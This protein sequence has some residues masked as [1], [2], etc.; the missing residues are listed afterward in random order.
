MAHDH[1]KAF[2]HH[3]RQLIGGDPAAALSDRQLLERFLADRDEAA[4][5]VLVRR[6]GPLVFGVCRRVLHNAH[7]A[8]DAFQATFLVLVRKAP[9]LVCDDR[10]GGF[11]YRVA[12]RLAVRAR[13]NEAR[14][15]QREVC[16]ALN[17]A[18]RLRRAGGEDDRVAALEEELQRLPEKHR[19]PLVLCY[20]EGKTNEQAA[21]ILC[22]PVGSMSARLN[23]ARQRLRESLEQR[24]VTV[25][26]AGIAALLSAAGTQAGVPLP[27]VCNTVRAAVWFAG[28]Q[29]GG[30]GFVSAGAVALARGAC[31]T[32]FL[33]RVNVIAA[34]LLVTALLGTMAHVLLGAAPP[35]LAPRAS[36]AHSERPEAL[37]RGAI[38]RMGSPRLRHGD[39]V[40]AAAYTPDGKQLLTA[41]RDRTVR[42]WELATGKETRRFAWGEVPPPAGSGTVDKLAQQ[43]LDKDGW[44]AHVALSRDGTLVA[45]CRGGTVR[46]WETATGKKRLD[47]QTNQKWLAQLAFSGDGRTLLGVGPGHATSLWDVATGKCLRRRAGKPVERTTGWTDVLKQTA[48]VSGGRKYLAW[49]HY[50][51]PNAATSIRIRDLATGKELPPISTNTEATALTFSPDEK[52]VV[53]AQFEGPIRVTEVATG[54]ELRRLGI[55]GEIVTHLAVSANGKSLAVCRENDLE[56]WDLPSGKRAARVEHG[57]WADAASFWQMRPVLAFSPDGKKLVAGRGRVAIRQFHTDT[58]KEIPP[59]G[60]S[61]QAPITGLALSADGKSVWTCGRGEALRCWDWA[62]GREIVQRPLPGTTTL[63]ALRA[64]GGFACLAG[65]HVHLYDAAGQQAGKIPTGAFSLSALA[66]STDGACLATRIALI[67]GNPVMHEVHLWDTRTMKVRYPLVPAGP[68]PAVRR[69]TVTQTAGVVP[70]DLV[71]SPDGRRLAGAGPSRQLCLW[72]VSTGTVLWERPPR[73]GEVIERFAFSP[74]G[75]CL[76]CVQADGTL[77]LLEA[78]GGEQRARLGKADLKTARVYLTGSYQGSSETTWRLDTPICL[79]FSPDERYLAV[80]RNTPVIHLWDVLAGREVGRLEGH[81]GG[82][83]SLLF[84]RDGKHLISGGTD[85]TA[86]TW[87]LDRLTQSP[88]ATRLKA[89]EREA[90]WADL[91]GK[92]AT[93]AFTAI[94][95]L[96]A[97]PEGAVGLLKERLRPTRPVDPR[98]LARLVADLQSDEFASRR[99]AQTELEGLGELASAALRKALADDP[100]LDLRQRLE[101]LLKRAEKGPLPGQMRELRGVEVLELIGSKAA[102]QVLDDL[103]GGAPGTRLTRQAGGAARRLASRAGKP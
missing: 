64:G 62:N 13:V 51:P 79:A 8:E 76:A 99:K 91:A 63:T 80:A 88:P 17:R 47:L 33:T 75:R 86:L 78:A 10:L 22:C 98:R 71:F 69:E 73:A 102:R 38:A 90:L 45:A 94:R 35:A 53:W 83:A 46:I 85:T 74:S 30:A 29:A 9:A 40:L 31:R 12:Y 52:T 36:R 56:L 58:G 14:R 4:V 3:V 60:S 54:K 72:D 92:D 103:A 49:Q 82:V 43:W 5:E 59:P 15:Q 44:G 55:R 25:G 100:P 16:A 50:P 18:D 32:M 67:R 48:L 95:K 28:E 19:A 61:H 65:R 41:G 27:L 23:Q 37:P 34:A 84:T 89:E 87:D 2:L 26:S 81:E 96:C 42:L 20:L 39:A 57:S 77:T 1:S 93:R 21:Q 7:A 66:L 24:G 11:L 6:Y 68:T 70:P 97:S 101:R